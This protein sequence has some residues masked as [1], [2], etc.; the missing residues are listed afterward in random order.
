M[1]TQSAKAKGRKLQQWICKFIVDSFWELEKDDV[2]SC[3]MGAGGVDVKLSPLAQKILKLSIESKN[4][5]KKPGP[6]ALKQAK[7]NMYKYTL[8]IVVWKPPGVNEEES[9][10]MIK[11]TDLIDLIKRFRNE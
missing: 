4:W 8:P 7:E 9:L 1:K 11:F 5:K 10:A 2:V 6:A 3:S